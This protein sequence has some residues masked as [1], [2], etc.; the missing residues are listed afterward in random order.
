MPD[1]RLY[2]EDDLSAGA[3]VA[4]GEDQARYLGQVLRQREG[5]G[6]RV[7]NGRD[8]EWRARIAEMGKRGAILSIDAQARAQVSSPDVALLFSPLK[9]QATDWLVEKATELGARLLQPVMCRRTVAETV[10]ADRLASIVRE[11]AEQTERLDVPVIGA[12]LTLARALDG[13]DASRP[14]IFADEAGDD[15]EKPWGGEKGRGD[16]LFDAATRLREK[17]GLSL[18]IGPEGG[19]DPEER[20]MLRGLSFVTPVS[21]GPRILRAESAAVAALAVLQAAWGDWR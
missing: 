11:A 18:L 5:A 15:Q 16:P 13:W 6:L 10:R 20:R 14:L 3:A 17:A 4:L 12:P 8:G 7:F 21:L 1:P 2:I 19:F 9:R